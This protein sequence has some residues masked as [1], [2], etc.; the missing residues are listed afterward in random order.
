MAL[1]TRRRAAETGG[2]AGGSWGW[3]S[4]VW[5]VMS[6]DAGCEDATDMRDE[7]CVGRVPLVVGCVVRG[8]AV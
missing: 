1:K 6:W 7:D 4:S 8:L 2:A 3:E 5:E